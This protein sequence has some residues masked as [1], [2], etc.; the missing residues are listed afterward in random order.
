MWSATI[1]GCSSVG[2][3]FHGD[4]VVFAPC[5]SHGSA[6]GVV[7]QIKEGDGGNAGAKVDAPAPQCRVELADEGL[8]RLA[9]VAPADCLD[10]N[11]DRFDGFAAGVGVDVV[12]VGASLAVTLEA[13]AEEVKALVDMG[14]LRLFRREAQAIEARV[15]K[16]VRRSGI[17]TVLGKTSWARGL[18]QGHAPPS[19]SIAWYL[20]SCA[21]LGARVAQNGAGIPS[22]RRRRVA[23]QATLRSLVAPPF[24][25]PQSYGSDVVLWCWRGSWRG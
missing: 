21:G 11:R 16:M 22:R 5:P 17:P 12:P 18:P 10:L 15:L 14:D 3:W 19:P 7:G 20:R 9:D 4:P 23:N 2:G 1:R 13:L 6:Q 8:E 24:C 25:Q